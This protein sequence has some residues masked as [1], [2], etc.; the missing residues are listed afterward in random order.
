MYCDFHNILREEKVGNFNT[1][2]YLST[3]TKRNTGETHQK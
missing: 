1:Y 2:L 3:C